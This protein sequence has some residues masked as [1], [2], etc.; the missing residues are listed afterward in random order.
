MQAL[1]L[2]DAPAIDASISSLFR[3]KTY[4]NYLYGRYRRRHVFSKRPRNIRQRFKQVAFVKVT[5]SPLLASC[6]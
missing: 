5:E 4:L 1:S 3:E 6:G 2:S